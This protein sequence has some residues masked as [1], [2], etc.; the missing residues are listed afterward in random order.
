MTETSDVPVR[1]ATSMIVIADRPE[2]EVL[3]LHRRKESIFVGGM[4]VFPGGAVD[5]GDGAAVSL[6]DGDP[7]VVGL[8]PDEARAHLVAGAR[9]TL[10]E[11]GLWVGL[12]DR[13]L[14]SAARRSVEDG[15]IPLDE[16]VDPGSIAADRLPY[17][18]HWVT[19]AGAPRR[20]DTRF[21][22]AIVD[23]IDAEKAEPD[24]T[25]VIAIEWERPQVAFE[26]LEHGDIE[27][28]APT[29]AFIAALAQFDRSQDVLAAA[30]K[31]DLIDRDGGIT[32]F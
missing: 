28:I 26:R 12:G 30:R 21:F 11:V 9:E 29:V 32:T 8:A 6:V 19:P 22:L 14:I 25:E 13:V 5:E 15:S 3:L 4:V 24:G 18:G 2:L 17:A 23:P 27:A 31:G 10:E 7:S 20:Y 1:A 16:V